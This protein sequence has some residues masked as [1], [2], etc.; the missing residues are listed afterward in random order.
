MCGG[1]EGEWGGTTH[2]YYRTVDHG[3]VTRAHR[4]L[5]TPPLGNKT[6]PQ[7]CELAVR[8]AV[9]YMSKV[10]GMSEY[11]DDGPDE[12]RKQMAQVRRIQGLQRASSS[13]ALREQKTEFGARAELKQSSRRAH[14]ELTQSSRRARAGALSMCG[15]MA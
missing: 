7:E 12:I 14:A 1:G 9:R 4:P 3:T 5:T 13:R 15:K 6:E 11:Q 10:P 2:A 8:V